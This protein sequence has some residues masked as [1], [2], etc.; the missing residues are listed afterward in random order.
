MIVLQRHLE[1][2]F[3]NLREMRTGSVFFVEHGLSN[4]EL[5]ELN[6]A[7]RQK[8]AVHS[9]E[10]HCWDNH[11]LPLL[12]AATE[13]GYRYRGAGT[14]FWPR[15]E[16]ELDT[17]FRATERQRVRDLF[18]SA[19]EKYNGARPPESSWARAFHYIAWPITH[20]LVPV[21]FHRSLAATLANLQIKVQELNDA[22]LYRAVR[23]A[24]RQVSARF[25]TW[26]SDPDLVV[27]ITRMLLGV[28]ENDFAKE[29]VARIIEDISHDDNARR[30]VAIARRLQRTVRT[31]RPTTP[32][33]QSLPVVKG[34]LRLRKCDGEITL[35]MSF[36]HLEHALFEPTRRALRRRRYTPRLWGVSARVPSEQLLSGLPFT[37]KLESKPGEDAEL[38]PGVSDLEIDDEQRELLRSLRMDF[39][40]PILFVVNADREVA[41]NIR[42]IEISGYKRYWLLASSADTLALETLPNLGNVGPYACIELDPSVPAAVAVLQKLNYQVQYGLSVGFAGAP[43]LDRDSAKL[44]FA[45]GD[46]RLVVPRRPLPDG[47]M[48]RF[49]EEEVPLIDDLVKISILEGEHVITVSS[50]NQSRNYGF[51]G[52][53]QVPDGSAHVCW[54]E[55]IAPE[56]S[57]QSLLAGNVSLRVE[58]LF[59]LEGLELTVEIEAAGRLVSVSIPL[60]PLPETIKGDAELW[61]NLLDESSRQFVLQDV[62]PT[63]HVRVGALA[64]GSWPLERRVRPCWWENLGSEISLRSELGTLAFGGVTAS[65]PLDRPVLGVTDDGIEAVLLAPLD[66]DPSTYDPSAAFT[67]LCVAPARMNLHTPSVQKPRLRR[68]RRAERDSTGLEDLME[69]YL[70]WA[71]AESVSLT[72]EI[73]RRQVMALLDNWISE[74][75]CGEIWVCHEAKFKAI[76]SDPWQ[77]LVKT[78]SMTGLGLDSYVELTP[79]DKAIVN[80]LAVAEIRRTR[81]E[82]WTLVGTPCDLDDGDYGTLDL[83][84]GRAYEQLADE[85]VQRGQE[86]LAENIAEGDPGAD[87]DEWDEAL[88]GVKALAEF[89]T[90][91]E[92]LSPSDTAAKLVA[93]DYTLMSLDDLTEEFI[94]WSHG[95]QRALSGGVVPDETVLEAILML[96]LAPERAVRLDW[97]GGPLDTLISERSVARVGR[98]MCLRSSALSHGGSV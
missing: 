34:R 88:Q 83:A 35:E 1:A 72:A 73:R 6:E 67:A 9:T 56:L 5:V 60:G 58:S 12:V 66:L 97:R 39:N 22:N 89:H 41:V 8:L 47:T 19:A 86:D 23:L 37:L 71:L 87:G 77:L 42:G 20:A 59:P 33:K 94:R 29:V 90:L 81:P 98:Y 40:P 2:R 46:I 84:C 7:L 45:E 82:L 32:K 57:V 49:G 79:G 80:R 85:Y 63:L 38:L 48:V 91:A 52:V 15:F 55:L 16:S 36:P 44:Q 28:G 30:D 96:W 93:L 26:L 4:I 95:A 70:R 43:P 69:A 53:K 31:S 14:D 21:E 17:V 50:N 24:A 78:L 54:I 18:V 62:H 27:K 64:F 61:A 75:C 76:T 51:Q 25:D 74:L 68:R 92:L 3:D 11:P 13:V 10:E 65:R